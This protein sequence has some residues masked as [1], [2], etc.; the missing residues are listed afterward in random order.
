M[1]IINAVDLFCG[2]GGTSTGLWHAAQAMG[3][4]INL[5][6]VNHWH[7]ALNTHRENHPWARH[8]HSLMIINFS[9]QRVIS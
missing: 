7:I 3:R 4:K 2:G 8:Y 1:S 9:E 6:A 5:I